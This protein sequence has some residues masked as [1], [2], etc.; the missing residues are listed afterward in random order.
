MTPSGIVFVYFSES[1][2]IS[3]DIQRLTDKSN[4]D[5][6]AD[7]SNLKGNSQDSKI[8]VFSLPQS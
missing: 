5:F 3:V 8:Q 7:A 1:S 4:V 6:S 2:L